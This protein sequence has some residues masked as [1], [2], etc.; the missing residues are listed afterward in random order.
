MRILR[1]GQLSHW[2]ERLTVFE[3]GADTAQ[4]AIGYA[5]NSTVRAA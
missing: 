2:A 3:E 5:A 1:P 4:A